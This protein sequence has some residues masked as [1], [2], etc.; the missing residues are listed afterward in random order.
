VALAADEQLLLAADRHGADRA[1]G[2]VAGDV[3][4]GRRLAVDAADERVGAL[5]V[6]ARERER[7][8][9]ERVVGGDHDPVGGHAAARRLDGAAA[10]DVDVD[11]VRAL[12][13]LGQR[14]A[15]REQVLA[16]VEL[17]LVLEAHGGGDVVGQPGLLDQRGRQPGLDRRLGLL[18][19]LRAVVGEVGVGRAAGASRTRSRRARPAPPSTP[20]AA[21][22]AAP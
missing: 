3:H 4:P 19:G 16:D 6:H 12:V 22:L 15:E 21:W 14:R 5:R 10:V 17:G 9:E 1:G 7:A 2:G 13:D 8:V 18:L 20:S 11:R